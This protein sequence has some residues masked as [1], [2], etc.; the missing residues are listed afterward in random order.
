[1]NDT[2]ERRNVPHTPGYNNPQDEVTFT[3]TYDSGTDEITVVASRE[4]FGETAVESIIVT[5]NSGATTVEEG[6]GFTTDS[7]TQVSIANGSTLGSSLEQLDFYGEQNATGAL[8]GVWV[9]PLALG[10]GNTFPVVTSIC[11]PAPNTV[12]FVGDR[13]LTA[14][15]GAVGHVT[16]RL[17]SYA[18]ELPLNGIGM[19][20]E[21]ADG[22]PDQNGWTLITHTDT[23]IE[24]SNPAFTT[25]EPA[26]GSGTFVV[27]GVAFHSADTIGMY[28]YEPWGETFNTPVDGAGC[29]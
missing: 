26:D 18:A 20:Y 7:A 24:I 27:T 3:V 6:V 25:Q 23:V 12:R 2:W 11:S 8:R 1:M 14:S 5:T 28:Y 17:A 29:P 13:F 10:S 15:V 16:T 4:F 21:L 9:G 19:Q 22:S